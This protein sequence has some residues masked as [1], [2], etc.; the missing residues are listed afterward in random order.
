MLALKHLFPDPVDI[1]SDRDQGD[2]H[3]AL[4][5]PEIGDILALLRRRPCTLEHV[6]A[7]LNVHITEVVK[8]IDALNAAGKVKTVVTGGQRFYVASGE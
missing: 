7:G 4:L 2:D 8:G 1:I 3:A 6:A 5:K